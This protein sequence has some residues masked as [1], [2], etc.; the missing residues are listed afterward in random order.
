MYPSLSESKE[1]EL[2]TEYFFPRGPAPAGHMTSEVTVLS[3]VS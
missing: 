3:V 2:E 1:A